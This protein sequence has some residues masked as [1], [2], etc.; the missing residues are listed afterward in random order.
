MMKGRNKVS[1]TMKRGI[2]LLLT[3][4]LI[5]QLTVTGIRGTAKAEEGNDNLL[6]NSDF[7]QVDGEKIKAWE[8]FA[9]NNGG[10]VLK[11]ATQQGK[12]GSTAALISPEKIVSGGETEKIPMELDRSFIASANEDNAKTGV[13]TPFTDTGNIWADWSTWE[14]EA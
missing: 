11:A 7:E 5:L 9:V 3:T 14:T 8:G 4:V 1:G 13:W 6:P 2:A 12:D 10:G